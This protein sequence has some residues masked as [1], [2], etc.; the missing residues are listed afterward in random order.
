MTYYRGLTELHY[1]V[2]NPNVIKYLKNE[3]I[4]ATS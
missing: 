4:Y 3:I 2:G 1:L